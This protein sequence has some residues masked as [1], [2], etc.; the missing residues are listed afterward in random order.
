MDVKYTVQG[1]KG[2]TCAE[3]QHFQ[4]DGAGKGKCFG[5][6]VVTQGSCNLFEKK[7]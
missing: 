5:H 2:K 6:E 4:A 1:E 7:E 3:C